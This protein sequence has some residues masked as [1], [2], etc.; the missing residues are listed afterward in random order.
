MKLYELLNEEE[1]KALKELN[2]R[3]SYIKDITVEE[4]T[5]MS[6]VIGFQWHSSVAIRSLEEIIFRQNNKL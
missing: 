4:L 3:N 1:K 2:I 6:D 5:V